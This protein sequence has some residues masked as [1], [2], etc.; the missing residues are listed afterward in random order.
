MAVPERINLFRV[1]ALR[2]VGGNGWRM[3]HNPYRDTLYDTVRPV[4]GRAIQTPLHIST[5]LV[6][7]L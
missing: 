2:G 1:Q 7:N 4:G 3:S 6:Q 5:V